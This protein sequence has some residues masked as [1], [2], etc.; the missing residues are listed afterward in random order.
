[1]KWLVNTTIAVLKGSFDIML[2]VVR[3]FFTGLV[4]WNREILPVVAAGLMET[5]EHA[6]VKLGKF[7]YCGLSIL[8]PQ[9]VTPRKSERIGKPRWEFPFWF[10][11]P[12]PFSGCPRR[13]LPHWDLGS[14]VSYEVSEL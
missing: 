11:L 1:V 3:Y 7:V 13:S 4:N 6:I 5:D 2:N 8:Q 12:Q 10:T 9:D 14:L